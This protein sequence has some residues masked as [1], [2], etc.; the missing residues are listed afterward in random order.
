MTELQDVQVGEARGPVEG[1]TSGRGNSPSGG[2]SASV[3]FAA[4]SGP[5]TVPGT[6]RHLGKS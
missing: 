5:C 3:S 2:A 4:L 1:S 6:W